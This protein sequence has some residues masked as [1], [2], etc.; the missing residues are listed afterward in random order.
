MS[1][2]EFEEDCP[3]CRPCIIDAK[4]GEKLPQDSDIMKA[5]NK[6]WETATQQEKQAF[7]NVTCNNSREA[8]D[9]ALMKGIVDRIQAATQGN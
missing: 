8:M 4:T 9:M 5:V 1:W 2:K 7:H 3:G 6:I